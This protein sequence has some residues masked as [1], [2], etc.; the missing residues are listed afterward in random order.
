MWAAVEDDPTLSATA[1]ARK[2]YG[3]FATAWRVRRDFAILAG[4]ESRQKRFRSRRGA[5]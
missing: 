5:E 4:A 2:T 1:L 3:S